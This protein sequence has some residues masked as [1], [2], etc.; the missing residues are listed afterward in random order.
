MFGET[1]SPK[2][3]MKKMFGETKSP[4]GEMKKCLEK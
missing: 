1:K 4:K 3:E 2:G